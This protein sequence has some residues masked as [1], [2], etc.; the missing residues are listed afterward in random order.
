MWPHSCKPCNHAAPHPQISLS[1]SLSLSLSPLQA[2]QPFSHQ[3]KRGPTCGPHIPHDAASAGIA[4]AAR[5]PGGPSAPAIAPAAPDAGWPTHPLPAAR[6][7]GNWRPPCTRP[8]APACVCARVCVCLCMRR[9]STCKCLSTMQAA[10]RS[11]VCKGGRGVA[12]EGEGRCVSF[13]LFNL[14]GVSPPTWLSISFL[15]NVALP[16]LVGVQVKCWVWFLLKMTRQRHS[17]LAPIAFLREAGFELLKQSEKGLHFQ[18][19]PRFAGHLF[20]SSASGLLHFHYQGT[21][22]KQAWLSRGSHAG[23]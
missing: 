20:F 18:A 10:R 17:G 21:Q 15:A 8:G 11:W 1:L 23:M 9:R 16:M 19:W 22:C 6:P 4:G 14:W 2:S 13:S 12:C 3:I 5:L 7:Q